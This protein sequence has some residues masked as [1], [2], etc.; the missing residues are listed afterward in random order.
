MINEEF[1]RIL[2]DALTVYTYCSVQSTYIQRIKKILQ[3]ADSHCLYLFSYVH[4]PYLHV[5]Y[6]LHNNFQN[7]S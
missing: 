7:I 1:C 5:K 6:V 4:A 3:N 2:H